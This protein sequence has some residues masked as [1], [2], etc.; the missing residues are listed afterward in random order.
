VRHLEKIE[1]TV[2]LGNLEKLI[3][4]FNKLPIEVKNQYFANLSAIS[5]EFYNLDNTNIRLVLVQEDNDVDDLKAQYNFIINEKVNCVIK[6]SLF[7]DFLFYDLNL[8]FNIS[9][10]ISILNIHS[11]MFCKIDLSYILENI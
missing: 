10:D 11:K 7:K 3:L 4:P 9:D 6:E 2:D 1:K 5:N 8:Y